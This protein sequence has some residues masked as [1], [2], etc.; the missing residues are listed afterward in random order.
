ME[1][2]E[3]IQRNIVNG[4][5]WFLCETVLFDL[6]EFS[7]Q[8][9]A[10]GRDTAVEMYDISLEDVQ[11][12]SLRQQEVARLHSALNK[13]G[14]LEKL[15]RAP[16]YQ[17][18]GFIVAPSQFH[19]KCTVL[20]EKQ[21]TLQDPENLSRE[22][23]RN[24]QES[25]QNR[26]LQKLAKCP[27]LQSARR[28]SNTI[29]LDPLSRPVAK[30]SSDTETAWQKWLR[31]VKSKFGS[32]AVEEESVAERVQRQDGHSEL[33]EG[34][35]VSEIPAKHIPGLCSECIRM[36]T[37]CGGALH[38]P[39]ATACL[40]AAVSSMYSRVH[41]SQSE[42]GVEAEIE[43]ATPGQRLLLQVRPSLFC[44][45]DTDVRLFG[46]TRH[47]LETRPVEGR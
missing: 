5:E 35:A 25:V 37:W 9:V 1:W 42:A 7:P 32:R 41:W 10:Q 31:S 8:L 47:Y 39:V 29:Y 43:T 40:D 30:A 20:P 28:S 34:A 46:S 12:A 38:L 44:I 11:R 45:P 36:G 16:A 22:K 27:Q 4:N 17:Y 6:F 26:L 23:R 19:L 14:V 3:V 2:A 18:P 33:P 24:L 21:Q 13:Q 15:P